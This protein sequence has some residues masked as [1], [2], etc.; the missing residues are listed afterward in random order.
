MEM[1]REKLI[2]SQLSKKK[3]RKITYAPKTSQENY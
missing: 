3:P 1:E 2:P